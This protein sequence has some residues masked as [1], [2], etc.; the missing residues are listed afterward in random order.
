MNKKP[1]AEVVTAFLSLLELSKLKRI[2]VTQDSLFGDINVEK[3][4]R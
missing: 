2:S 1:K 4:K 3:I